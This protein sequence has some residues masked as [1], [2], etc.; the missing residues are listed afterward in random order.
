MIVKVMNKMEEVNDV[1]FVKYYLNIVN[2]LLFKM[3]LSR[4]KVNLL[5]L[6]FLLTVIIGFN[7]LTKVPRRL[8]L[9]S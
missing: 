3:V 8:I 7:M 1:E 5:T 2:V 9:A 4:I 6:S